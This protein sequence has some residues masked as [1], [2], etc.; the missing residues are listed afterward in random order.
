MFVWFFVWG[1]LIRILSGRWR[2]WRSVCGCVCICLVFGVSCWWWWLLCWCCCGSCGIGWGFCGDLWLGGLCVWCFYWYLCCC[3]WRRF[4]WKVCWFLRGC[5]GLFYCVLGWCGLVLLL[6]VVLFVFGLL[7][8]FLGVCVWCWCLLIGLRSW[9]NG[10]W[11]NFIFYSLRFWWLWRVVVFFGLIRS[12]IY[13][14]DWVW[15]CVFCCWGWDE[16]LWGWLWGW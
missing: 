3:W 9:G 11:W 1:W 8:L 16:V 2:V 6:W 4:W 7:W 12:G 13:E 15:V 10:Y 5:V 14:F